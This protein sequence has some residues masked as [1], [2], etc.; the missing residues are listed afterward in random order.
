MSLRR[1]LHVLTQGDTNFMGQQWPS[2]LNSIQG[3][4]RPG[5]PYHPTN[6]MLPAFFG[7]EAEARN[8]LEHFLR[9]EL[10]Q[11]TFGTR[12]VST[13]GKH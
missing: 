5:R 10:T 13:A 6:H 9:L 2:I 12:D 1:S 7:A 8:S 4:T 3:A 11:V